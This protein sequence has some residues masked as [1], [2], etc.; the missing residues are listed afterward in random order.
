[1]T[2]V[3]DPGGITWPRPFRVAPPRSSPTTYR[4]TISR[5]KREDIINRT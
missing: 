5:K 1:M 3:L 4:S 2:D